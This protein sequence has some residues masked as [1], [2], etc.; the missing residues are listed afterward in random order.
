MHEPS[1]IIV[2]GFA[3]QNP[4]KHAQ[5][6]LPYAHKSD[7][8]VLACSEHPKLV[9]AFDSLSALSCCPGD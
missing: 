6:R 2:A 4:I 8:S 5:G 9:S 3:N 7:M 1:S